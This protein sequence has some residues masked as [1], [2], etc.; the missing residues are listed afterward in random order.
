MKF[1]KISDGVYQKNFA[2]N[3]SMQ[4]DFNQKK[5]F[6]PTQIKNHDR[7]SIID[8]SHKENF[9]VFECIHR[10]LQKG[11]KPENIT[12]E[13][14]WQLGHDSKSGR[15]DICISDSEN[16]T[17]C[18]IECKTFG[19]EYYKELKN[20]NEDGGQ[21]FSYW[22]QER[23]CK[24]LVLYSSTFDEE[25]N[26]IIPKSETVDC[27]DDKNILIAAEKNPEVKTYKTSYTVANL[28][29][30]WAD[31]YEK[32]LLGNLFFNNDSPAYEVEI[33][34][35][36][37]SDLIDFSET[38][39]I[40]NKFE[41]ILRHNNV[42]DKENAFN[43][44]VA[45][46]ICKLVDESQKNFNDEVDFQYKIGSDSYEI[47]QDRLQRL[48]RDGMEKFMDEKI[49]YLPD[50]YAENLI[51]QYFGADRENMLNDL[52]S[53]LR[54]LKF[55]TNNDFAFKDVHNEE[56]FYQNGKILVEVVR[57][58][59]NYRIIGATNLQTL[60]DLF[61]QLLDKGF[62]QDEGQF[63]TPLPITRFIWD[64]LPLEKIISDEPPKI[65]DYAC[66]AGFKKFA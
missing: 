27:S 59:Q 8:K 33:K 1:E 16:K 57:L 11:Y 62:K 2:E 6:Y 5:F 10:L 22:Q 43:R 65:I 15:A 31:T 55:F 28:Y 39:G 19:K 26:K 51:Q 29:E 24:W 54:K 58:F 30:T 12:L 52:Q 9:V 48:H 20:L 66:G 36:K 44:L 32:K 37:N 50:N 64:S 4:A 13:K 41:E 40:V 45:L 56:L 21:L 3:I 46:F 23:A 35:L 60:G 34:L 38:D 63:F 42:S 61:E 18:I 17:Y 25:K 49:F 7:N 53:N 47:L 14:A